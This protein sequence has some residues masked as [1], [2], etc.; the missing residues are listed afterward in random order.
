MARLEIEIGAVNDELKKILQ[1]SKIALTQFQKEVGGGKIAL[2][3]LTQVSKETKAALEQQAIAQEK[4][5]TAT[6]QARQASAELTLANRQNK[7]SVDA[8]AGSYR[9]A[10]QRLTALGKSIREAKGGFDSTNPA[11]RAQ[12]S[13][14]NNLNAK[15]KAFDA[16]MG[17][18]QR[19][20]GN[21]AL[22]MA[23]ANGVTMEFT[24]II[25][26]A[27][28]GMM[29]IGNNIQQLTA[30]WQQYAKSSQEAAAAQ[31]K[32]VTTGAL[33]RNA[34]SSMIS[35]AGLLTLG[36]AALTSGWVLYEKWQQKSKKSTEELAKAQKSFADDLKE[37]VSTLDSV[38]QARLEGERGAISETVTI[39]ALKRVIEDETAS[40][41]AR[42]SAI[43][44]LKQ[45][46][47]SYFKNIDN[48]IL[49]TG[50]A[51]TAYKKLTTEILNSA[52][53]RAAQQKIT[54]EAGKILDITERRLQRHKE[55]NK[56]DQENIKL[57]EQM[58]KE[59]LKP[60]E[61]TQNQADNVK[62]L[63]D[64]GDLL[65]KTNSE[66]EKA[67][68][69]QAL[70]Q[71]RINELKAKGRQDSTEEIKSVQ[72]IDRLQEDVNKTLLD[73]GKIISG[74]NDGLAS[75]RDTTKEIGYSTNEIVRDS[76]SYYDAK[77]FDINKKYDE[78]YQKVKDPDLL[79]L[80]R[81]NE[82]AEK[83]RL[84]IEKFSDSLSKIK[85]ISGNLSTT[86]TGSINAGSLP[87]LNNAID[88]LN[89]PIT[90]NLDERDQKTQDKLSKIVERGFRQGL[91][92]VFSEIDDLGSNFY[93]VFT[94]V[95]GKLSSSVTKIFTD[96]IST[97]IGSLMSKSWDSDAFSIAGLKSDVSKA[98]VA[99]AGLAGQAMGS[100]FKATN[101]AGQAL[102]GGLSGAASGFAIGSSIGGIGGPIGAIAGGLIG[103]L[104]G[105]FGA[106]ARKKQ[107]EIAQQQLE[108]QKKQTALQQRM[109]ALTFTSSIV[110]Q[111]TNQGIITGASRNEF[112]DF[113][114]RVEGRDLVLVYDRE[115]R[116]QS[117][118][119]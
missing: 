37:F 100:M 62:W 98:I 46:Y 57:L 116:A 19:Q 115:K 79:G 6:Q 81:Q 85:P 68:V 11:I 119:I 53:A 92:S 108:E 106:K 18:H 44:Q 29:G 70:N 89:R 69:K 88:R 32:T 80:A 10:Q 30:N 61:L 38:T 17:N 7:G 111:Q 117:R 63:Q 113:T 28:F 105:I 54:D 51:E 15:L 34:L 83:L 2:G 104:S 47:P 78:I 33:L 20:V 35:P 45:Q 97:Q 14:Y 23:N 90:S 36:V 39:K 118:G 64:F 31:G 65:L 93:E 112:G 13:E 50:K 25:Q 73:G 91:D 110:G 86:I 94:N 43:N 74:N 40:R 109:A 71:A 77:L 96:V 27:P 103:V 72:Y 5:K 52:K 87:G 84:N 4:A 42:L 102:A 60:I 114:I 76:L 48:E 67:Q 1:D 8:A 22:G 41:D 26:D 16:Q 12:I 3:G 95:F 101:Q 56:L 21:Y 75:V 55:I 66:A 59:G 99:G 82:I 24:R 9:E 58:N 49:L 107:E